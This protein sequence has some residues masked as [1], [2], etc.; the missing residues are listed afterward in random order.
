MPSIQIVWTTRLV[1]QLRPVCTHTC[2]AKTYNTHPAK[3]LR[4]WTEKNSQEPPLPNK[5]N[6]N[7][8]SVE[9]DTWDNFRSSVALWSDI[10][11]GVNLF[12]LHGGI[13]VLPLLCAQYLITC[14]L[15]IRQHWFSHWIFV[16]VRYFKLKVK[17]SRPKN[18]ELR[19]CMI[20]PVCLLATVC[21]VRVHACM[22]VWDRKIEVAEWLG[23]TADATRI[24][25]MRDSSWLAVWL[26]KATFWLTN[27]TALFHNRL[28]N[29]TTLFHNWLTNYITLFHTWL[30]NHTTISQLIDRKLLQITPH[31]FTVPH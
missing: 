4:E 1:K 26:L 2:A 12:R 14:T 10:L 3:K 30:T 16:C 13:V 9:P 31:Y 23:N 27:N 28:T 22:Y 5:T 20:C 11:F 18:A 21:C 17:L 8:N 29:H 19:V 15:C 7:S 24:S 6:I 25:V